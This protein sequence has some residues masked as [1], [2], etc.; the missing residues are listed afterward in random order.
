MIRFQFVQCEERQYVR[1]VEQQQ[2]VQWEHRPPPRFD[3]MRDLLAR[4]GENNAPSSK[5]G[6]SI[7]YGHIW[8]KE[9]E[10]IIPM[11]KRYNV[12]PRLQFTDL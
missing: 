3:G 11:P 2:C 1:D 8:P 4:K 7:P 6:L 9:V 10:H 5:E 12:W